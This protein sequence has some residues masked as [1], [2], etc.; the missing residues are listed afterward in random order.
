[1]VN[2]PINDQHTRKAHLLDGCPRRHGHVVEI[3]EAP[4]G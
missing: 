1:M 3:A 4:D 2:V